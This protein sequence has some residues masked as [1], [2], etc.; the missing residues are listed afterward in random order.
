MKEVNLK[1]LHSVF[2]IIRHSGKSKTV[3]TAKS[4]MVA[5]GW[6]EGL[7]NMH[8][9]ED[10]QGNEITLCDA[11]TINTCHYTYVSTPIE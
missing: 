4:S 3:E 1:R 6:G 11:I 10:F 2:P 9:T 8:S 5:S 7:M